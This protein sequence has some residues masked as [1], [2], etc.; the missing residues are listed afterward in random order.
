MAH[1]AFQVRDW[2]REP[3]RL[4]YDPGDGRRNPRWNRIPVEGGRAVITAR[5]IV[6]GEAELVALTGG[7]TM[8]R[9]DGTQTHLLPTAA[10][11]VIRRM[12][13][14]WRLSKR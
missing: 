5:V 14:D 3:I 1:I 8:Y 6:E 7:W 12:P 9:R 10:R 11:E 2:Q 13:R 4:E